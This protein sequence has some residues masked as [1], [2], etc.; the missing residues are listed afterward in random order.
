[1]KWGFLHLAAVIDWHS[2]KILL[3]RLSNT[4]HRD[5]CVEAVHEA[6]QKYGVPE[7]MNTD[8]AASLP[9]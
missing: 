9:T 6:I 5:F 8:R 1:M 4:M 7:I 3:L 2:R